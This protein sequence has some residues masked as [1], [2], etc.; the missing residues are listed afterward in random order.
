MQIDPSSFQDAWKLFL[1]LSSATT[2]ILVQTTL[3]YCEE[4]FTSRVLID[5]IL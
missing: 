3:I 2:T 5:F 1:Q 4:H